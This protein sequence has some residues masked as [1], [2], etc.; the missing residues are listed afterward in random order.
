[1]KF[2]SRR[3]PKGGKLLWVFT[4]AALAAS[5][6]LTPLTNAQPRKEG[7]DRPASQPQT[8]AS[9]P[10]PAQSP[11]PASERERRAAAYAKLL[12]GQR[13][14]K[15]VRTDGPTVEALRRSQAAFKKAAELD[16]TLAE[17][18]TALAEIALFFDD[19]QQS[20]QEGLT[21]SRLNPDNYG[22]HRILSRVYTVK[23]KIVEDKLDR[24]IADKAV[25]E[26][27]EVIRVH[28]NDAEAWALLAEF[29]AATGRE[30][31]AI[32]ALR[33]WAT[34]PASTEGRFYQ[35][36][37][38]GRELS[39]DAANARLGE[40]LLR[41][42]QTAEAVEAIRRALSIEPENTSYLKLLGDALEA[43]GV[44]DKGVI[45][46]LGRI[47]AQQPQNA[48]AIQMLARAQSRAGRVDDAV[49]TIRAGIAA[50]KPGN[51]NDR[52][53][54]QILLADT[55]SDASRYDDAVAVYEDLLKSRNI[56]DLPLGSERDR[57]F[58]VAA[59]SSIISLRKQAGQADE[60]L[61]T[62]ERMRRLVGGG[63]PSADVQKTDL[64]RSL[65]RRAEALEAVR[66]ARKRFPD[67]VSLLR[68]E[69]TTLAELGRSDE[70][71][72][73]LRPRLKGD[74]SDYIE[75]LFMSSL[76][77]SA[78]RGAEAVE[79]AR[80]AL[81]LASAEDPEQTSNALIML[82]SAQDRA[83][84]AKGSE[85]TLRQ[86]LAKDQ[87]NPTALNNLGY[88]LTER[89]ERFEE[90]LEMIQR[91]VRADPTNPSF[92][93]SLG[94]VYFKLG[95]LKEA[96]RYLSDAARRNPSSAAIQ[97]HLGDLF[98]R[99]GQR[100]KAQ[101]AWRKALSLTV[102]AADSTRIKAKLS[103]EANK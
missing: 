15:T 93:D 31:E 27:R 102:E 61:A 24:A 99:L 29:Y 77:I 42:G 49:A 75:Y 41:S 13:Y 12:E 100:E 21:A 59:L 67:E 85:E 22:A 28:P 97:E 101:T 43:N 33:K 6:V 98:Q 40:L 53:Q 68:L 72:G 35:V 103:G 74:A 17:A 46:E 19:L 39:P 51:D 26:L 62:V 16:P 96:E 1:M 37:T 50:V 3:A 79:S 63:D 7:A 84:D 23:S 38:R 44:A 64:L 57:R 90:A 52:L 82:S 5:A 80:K 45:E 73:L 60:A 89:N 32:E 8:G 14:F 10:T 48:A 88:F 34:L 69:A 70:A 11:T 76:L 86:I 25:A 94:W 54:L 55:F 30:K 78:G 47:V 71:L 81:A 65:G 9:T 2:Y 92:L 91:A 58:A 18:H 4:F 36:I 87:N 95:K 56:G 20:E 66:D 83:G